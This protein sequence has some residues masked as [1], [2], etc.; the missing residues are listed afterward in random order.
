M[1]LLEIEQ[2]FKKHAESPADLEQYAADASVVLVPTTAGILI[3]TVGGTGIPQLSL[4]FSRNPRVKEIFHESGSIVSLKDRLFSKDS[5]IEEKVID[6]THD[7][8]EEW[9]LPGV[10]TTNR[11]ITFP[12]VIIT[13]ILKEKV[14]AK[15]VYWDQ[16][17]VLRQ[18][19]LIPSDVSRLPLSAAYPV[20]AKILPIL[21]GNEQTSRVMDEFSLENSNILVS[22]MDDNEY[23]AANRNIPAKKKVEEEN[24]HSSQEI[25]RKAGNNPYLYSKIKPIKPTVIFNL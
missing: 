2:V 24:T 10:R 8:N 12:L 1:A 14:V 4:F 22:K 20:H 11:R 6:F 21:T 16:G 17:T 13:Q 7:Q 5:V 3:L 9:I 15:R 18:I 25:P 23:H 19:G